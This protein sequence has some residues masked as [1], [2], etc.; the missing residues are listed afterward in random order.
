M[1][2]SIARQVA[3][4]QLMIA[5][6]KARLEAVRESNNRWPEADIHLKQL[7][8]EEL[9]AALKTLRWIEANEEAIRKAV[10]S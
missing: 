9:D 7:R 10:R 3:C 5:G 4:I 8:L 1:S 2:I 6:H